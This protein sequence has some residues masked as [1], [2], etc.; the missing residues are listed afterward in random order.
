MNLEHVKEGDLVA[1]FENR[2]LRRGVVGKTTL[3]Q[4]SI[5]GKKFM[6]KS[7]RMVGCGA[8]SLYYPNPWAE[9]WEPRHDAN[10][11]ARCVENRLLRSRLAL[12]EFNWFLLTQPQADIV[13]A[14]MRS[15]GLLNDKKESAE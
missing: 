10:L 8:S 15:A 2:T 11:I 9:P 3:T 6:R 14:A 4:V 1:V 5:G 12:R 7:G 13:L